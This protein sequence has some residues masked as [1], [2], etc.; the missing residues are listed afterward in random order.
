MNRNRNVLIRGCANKDVD[1][2]T[3]CETCD[4]I[5]DSFKCKERL[6]HESKNKVLIRWVVFVP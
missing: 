6:H 1:N 3:V 5:E 4:V 2:L